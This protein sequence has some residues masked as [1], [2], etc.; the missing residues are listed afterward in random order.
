MANEENKAVR[1]QKAYRD[2]YTHLDA[3]GL[4]YTRHDDDKVIALTMHGDDLP[5]EMLLLVLRRVLGT[6][7]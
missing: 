4:K 7:R 2:L 1:A 5:I 6:R 3:I